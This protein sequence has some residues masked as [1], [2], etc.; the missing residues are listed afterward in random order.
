MS[1]IGLQPIET[2]YKG[3]RFRSRLEARWAVFFDAAGIEWEYEPEGFRIGDAP[4]L[5]DF[6]LSKLEF[7]VEVKPAKEEANAAMPLIKKFVEL[8]THPVLLIAGAPSTYEQMEIHKV[9]R[10]PIAFENRVLV[11]VHRVSWYQ[12]HFCNA[13]G[14]STTYSCDCVPRIKLRKGNHRDDGNPRIEY[15]LE[16]AQTARFEHGEDGRPERYIAARKFETVRVYAAGA[17]LDTENWKNAIEDEDGNEFDAEFE[18]VA[19]WRA[20][21][22][23]VVDNY[24]L[25]AGEAEVGRFRYA[26]PTI[27]DSHG[28]AFEELASRCLD[29]LD[30]ADVVFAWVDRLDTIGTIAEIGAAY[31]QGKPILIAFATAELADHF[32]FIEQLATISIIAPDALMAWRS[33]MQWQDR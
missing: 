29:E 5:P 6:W 20:D 21:I 22:F 2:R 11:N 10:S 26:G 14:I 3:Y 9:Y 8:G 24:G 18:I 32:Y 17:V 23:G 27:L 25:H 16:Q 31:S 19:R 15:A 13:V 7:F 28:Q 33:F 4:Y 30:Q 12:C 1:V